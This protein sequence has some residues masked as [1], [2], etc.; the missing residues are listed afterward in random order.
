MLRELGARGG[1]GIFDDGRSLLPRSLLWQRGHE[2]GSLK[3]FDH[4]TGQRLPSWS[5]MAYDGPIDF[6]DLKL[7][8]VDWLEDE[9]RGPWT[10]GGEA[11]AQD[12][13]A[14]GKGLTAVARL[15]T[16]EPV[17]DDDQ[18]DSEVILDGGENMGTHVW[19]D[20]R[21]IV[22]GTRRVSRG[23]KLTPLERRTH[24][25]LIV[26]PVGKESA[27]YMR[28]GVGRMAGKVIGQRMSARITV[29]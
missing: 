18:D 8:E 14:G 12:T 15:F 25:F 2:V 26:A 7:G 27:N 11:S 13:M 9:V 10:E 6:M 3:R 21:C 17:Y 1:F 24:Y 28:I 4:R 5:W 20:W 22:V 19:Q 23:G 29:E 16:Q